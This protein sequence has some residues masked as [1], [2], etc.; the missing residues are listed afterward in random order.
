MKKSIYSKK[1]NS[2]RYTA[3][4]LVLFLLIAAIIVFATITLLNPFDRGQHETQAPHT[5]APDT[6]KD[7]TGEDRDTE[8]DLT[9]SSVPESTAAPVV[10]DPPVVT[11]PPVVTDPPVTSPA[12]CQHTYG[13]WTETQKAT[14][15][16]HGTRTRKCSKCGATE[17]GTIAA[18]GHKPVSDPTVPATCTKTGLTEGSHCS[19]CG[20][21]IID[22]FA[23]KNNN[24]NILKRQC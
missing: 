20:A 6:P 5:S 3:L 9:E 15:T 8:P 14:C 17:S 10:T 1:N 2:G 22:R 12:V 4:L 18:I 7:T 21:V 24:P 11:E 13:N 19:V 16:A 23:L